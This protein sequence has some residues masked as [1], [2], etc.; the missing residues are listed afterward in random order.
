MKY[1]EQIQ[2]FLRFLNNCESDY[3]AA[4][5]KETEEN[6]KTQ[7]LL[8]NLE[9]QSNGYHDLARI[10][11]ALITVRRER[12][13]AKDTVSQLQPIIE[14]T[15]KNTKVLKELEKLL[16]EVRKIERHTHNR[17]YIPKTDIVKQTLEKTN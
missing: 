15:E 17:M 8:H 10:S 4:I 5:A 12:R 6:N 11:K 14:W 7:D 1:S 2:S 3:I 16:G 13:E 9:L